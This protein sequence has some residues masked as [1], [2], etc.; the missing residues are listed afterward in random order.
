MFS[1]AGS[2]LPGICGGHRPRVQL[3]SPVGAGLLAIRAAHSASPRL[4]HRYR[5]QAGSYNG[6]GGQLVEIGRLSGRHRWQASSH[7]RARAERVNNC[8]SKATGSLTRTAF[9]TKGTRRKGETISRRYRSD[10]Y[11]LKLTSHPHNFFTNANHRLSF[12]QVRSI[13]VNGSVD[14]GRFMANRFE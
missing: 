6:I 12:R 9:D 4:I 5:Q 13:C 10:R 7:R 8:K 14:Y 11:V 2:L 3:Q 1:R